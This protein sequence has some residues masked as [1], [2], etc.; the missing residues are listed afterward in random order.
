MVKLDKIPISMKDRIGE[1]IKLLY[2]IRFKNNYIINI[3]DSWVDEE[4]RLIH[5]IC[6]I[7]VGGSLRSLLN[8]INHIKL[9]IILQID[10]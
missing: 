2:E 7:A 5:F 3:H 4:K 1:E 9:R 8:T 10:I 6:D